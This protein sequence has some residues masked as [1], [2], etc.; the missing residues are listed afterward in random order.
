MSGMK[1]FKE[2]AQSLEEQPRDAAWKRLEDKLEIGETKSKVRWYR[3]LA[4]AASLLAILS[5][6]SIYYHQMHDHN[7][8]LFAYNADK[9]DYRPIQIEEITPLDDEGLYEID[10]LEH[11]NKAIAA[12]V[13]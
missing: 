2:Y 6:S 3:S 5:V 10:R 11:L 8:D 1:N 4:I 12:Y 7:P 13:R 9:S